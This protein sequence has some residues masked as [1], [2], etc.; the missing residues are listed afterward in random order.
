ME[1]GLHQNSY[2]KE[3]FLLIITYVEKHSYI[4]MKAICFSKE[5]RD[6]N[7]KGKTRFLM[8]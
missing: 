8:L 5:R 6:G 1:R 7:K 3:V 2:V 4:F